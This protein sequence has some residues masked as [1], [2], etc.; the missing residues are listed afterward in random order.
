M[1]WAEIGISQP[2]RQNSSIAVTQQL[3]SALLLH[4]LTANTKA[5]WLMRQHAEKQSDGGRLENLSNHNNFA[6]NYQILLKFGKLVHGSMP[7]NGFMYIWCS[8]VTKFDCTVL[9]FVSLCCGGT[10][11]VYVL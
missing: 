7:L 11:S 8:E 5:L 3:Q 1:K 6:V 10:V 4:F 2:T 9:V